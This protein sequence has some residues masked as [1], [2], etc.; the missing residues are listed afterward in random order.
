M[1]DE[2][3]EESISNSVKLSSTWIKNKMKSY[4]LNYYYSV[5]KGTWLCDINTLYQSSNN[6]L[7]NFRVPEDIE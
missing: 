3:I 1:V 4:I 6:W 7:S 2:N 5:G